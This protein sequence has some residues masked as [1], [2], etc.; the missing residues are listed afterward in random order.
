M[1]EGRFPLPAWLVTISRVCLL[2]LCVRVSHL[3]A[4]SASPPRFTLSTGALTC[5]IP[6]LPLL[7][8]GPRGQVSPL[9]WNHL[10]CPWPVSCQLSERRAEIPRVARYPTASPPHPLLQYFQ[11]ARRVVTSQREEPAMVLG[12]L[13]PTQDG[14]EGEHPRVCSRGSPR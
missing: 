4:S 2:H 6:T 8:L 13:A 9:Q 12:H 10:L 11:Q 5:L 1:G 14:V 7:P 3:P